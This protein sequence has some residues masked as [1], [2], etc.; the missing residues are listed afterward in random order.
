M[1]T[2]S[3]KTQENKHHTVANAVSQKKRIGESTF[4]FVDNRPKTFAQRRLQQMANNY[5]PQ[6]SQPI[7]KQEHANRRDPNI[8]ATPVFQLALDGPADQVREAEVL[9]RHLKGI[10]PKVTNLSVASSK[11]V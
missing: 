1:Y 8:I 4:Q 11:Y 5:S 10:S 6:Q 9:E 3:D 7:Q 2:Y